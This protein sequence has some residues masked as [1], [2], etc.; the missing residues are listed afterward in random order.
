MD[1]TE[2]Y[3]LYG[4]AREQSALAGQVRSSLKPGEKIPERYTVFRTL[5]KGSDEAETAALIRVLEESPE[6]KHLPAAE[7][8]RRVGDL[9]YASIQ[10]SQ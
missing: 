4:D 2:F 8:Q 6:I 10:C 3:A 7:R 9:V 5:L 1:C